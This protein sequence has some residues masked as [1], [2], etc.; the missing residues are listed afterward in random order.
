MS[1]P[2]WKKELRQKQHAEAKR[3]KEYDALFASV[4]RRKVKTFEPYVSQK[5]TFI[6][7][8]PYYPSVKT[9]DVIPCGPTPK[10]ESQKYTGDLIVGIGTMHKSNMVPIM[11]GTSQAEDIAKMRRG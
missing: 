7:E 11:R 2:K 8:T 3:K 10:R 4:P 1:T 6:R 9:S 5:Q